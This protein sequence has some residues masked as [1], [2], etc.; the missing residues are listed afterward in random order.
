MRASDIK[1]IKYQDTLALERRRRFLTRAAISSLTIFGV[2]IAILGVIF[3]SPW[4]R[5]KN[6]SIS[7][8]QDD[9]KSQINSFIRDDLSK[10]FLGIPFSQNILFLSQNKLR[11][12]LLSRFTF[13]NDINIS[14]DYPHNL[15]VKGN[16]RQPAGVWCFNISNNQDCKYFDKAGIT[17]GKAAQSTGFI[18]LNI[19]DLREQNKEV[20]DPMFLKAIEKVVDK[21]N[22]DKI[23]IK[24]ITIPDGS[25]TEFDVLIK[26]G[27]YIRFAVDT[28]I[29]HQIDVIEI[30]KKQKVDTNQINP[31][32]LDVRFEDRVYYK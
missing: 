12:Q 14:K 23:M 16:E 3:F 29:D 21:F 1:K 10:K 27:Y 13:L 8:L 15:I 11:A 7:D 5:I 32:Y 22:L 19:D 20:I 31:Q 18:L 28:D 24:N 25:F 4:L 17:W 2:I 26:E 30:F 6:I 9:H